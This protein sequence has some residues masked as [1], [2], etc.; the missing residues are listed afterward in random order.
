MTSGDEMLR[1]YEQIY[2][3]R[4]SKCRQIA[5]T[6]GCEGNDQQQ[7]AGCSDRDEAHPG[8][9]AGACRDHRRAGI[10]TNVK[11]PEDHAA[12]ERAGTESPAWKKELKVPS[13]TVRAWQGVDAVDDLIAAQEGNPGHRH[14]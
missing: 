3:M 14:T 11:A 13:Y 10:K 12:G 6:D 1:Q 5:G 9:R 4:M 2:F 8:Q 7:R